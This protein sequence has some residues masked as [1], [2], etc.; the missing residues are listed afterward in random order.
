MAECLPC[1]KGYSSIEDLIKNAVLGNDCANIR[2]YSF[3]TTADLIPPPEPPPEECIHPQINSMTV[4]SKSDIRVLIN[5]GMDEPAGSET[6]WAVSDHTIFSVFAEDTQ[7]WIINLGE[8]MTDGELPSVS[9]DGVI[10]ILSTL[11]DCP[12][13]AFT[14]YHTI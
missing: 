12:L 13:L 6:S 7:T 3:R 4:I 10:P 5:M 9:Y 2:K 8:D 1:E 14:N 11:E